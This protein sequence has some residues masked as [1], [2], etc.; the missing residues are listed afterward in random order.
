MTAS[1]NPSKVVTRLAEYL[2]PH[3]IDES[4]RDP[5]ALINDA[6]CEIDRLRAALTAAR[7]MHVTCE[8]GWYSCPLSEDGCLDERETACTCGAEKHN[9]AIDIALGL[10]TEK[11]WHCFHCGKEFP[12]RASAEHHLQ[13]THET[14]T[15]DSGEPK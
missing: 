2:A 14:V 7:R 6:I 9:A 4:Q 15:N 10:E 3:R 8:D 5:R 1:N 11:S 13:L 12:S